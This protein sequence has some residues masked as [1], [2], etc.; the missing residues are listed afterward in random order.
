[1]CFNWCALKR[2][3]TPAMRTAPVDEIRELIYRRC[4]HDD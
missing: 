1:M 3:R 2:V 4:E